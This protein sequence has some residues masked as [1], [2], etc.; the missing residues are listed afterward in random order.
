MLCC[1]HPV[2]RQR[3]S[4]LQPA[5]NAIRQAA[6]AHCGRLLAH[7]GGAVPWAVIQ[8]GFE[9]NGERI[10]LGSTPRGIHRPVQMRRGVLSIKTT[11]P[12]HGRVARYD[13]ALR[14]DGYFSYAFQGEDARARDNVALREAFE[15]QTPFLYFYA[16]TAGVY[17]ILFPCYVND[18]SPS[19]LSCTV[20][21]GSISEVHVAGGIRVAREIDRRYATVAAKVRLHQAEFREIVL[22]A[23]DRR[24]AISGLPLMPLLEAA[25]IIPDRDERG[26]PDVRN[27]ICLSTLHHAA[28]DRNLLGIDPDGVI[29]VAEAV[30]DQHDGPTLE[31]GIKG[32][33]GRRLR[34]PRHADECPNRDFLAERFE[35]FRHSA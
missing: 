5:D 25:H 11:K 18:W 35:A 32:F 34:L 31:A 22:A 6:F 13:D 19:T 8:R 16:L 14:D 1:V 24:C 27:G 21:V 4:D 10:F 15:D 7:H 33:H 20:A 9:L 23:Y 12:R 28:Y 3:L 26:N 29:H 30:L 2:E 17:E